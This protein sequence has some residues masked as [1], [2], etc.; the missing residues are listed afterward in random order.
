MSQLEQAVA[1]LEVSEARVAAHEANDTQTALAL[2]AQID[3]L[4]AN[5]DPAAAITSLTALK[6]RIDAFDTDAVAEAAKQA[7]RAKK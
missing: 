7:A 4:K 1:D 3:A 6:A 5:G 2:Q